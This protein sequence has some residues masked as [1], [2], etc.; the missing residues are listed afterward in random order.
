[1]AAV[2]TALGVPIMAKRKVS[3]KSPISGRSQRLKLSAEESLKRM[4][5]FDQRKEAFIA[6]VRKGKNRGLSA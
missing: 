1:M 2:S 6:A 4:Q 5:E 3:K